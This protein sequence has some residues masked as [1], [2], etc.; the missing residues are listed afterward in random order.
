MASRP[1]NTQM[2]HTPIPPTTGSKGGPKLVTNLGTLGGKV[3]PLTPSNSPGPMTAPSA[4][5]PVQPGTRR[6]RRSR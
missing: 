2:P 1:V 4:Q 3:A 5:G 6:P